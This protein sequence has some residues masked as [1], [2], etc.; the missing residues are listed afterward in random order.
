[1]KKINLILFGIGN[2]GATLL[3][4]L[5]EAREA[6]KAEGI[7]LSIPVIAGSE[8]VL[9]TKEDLPADW[10]E[11]FREKAQDYN[12]GS[13]LKFVSEKGFQN[14]IAIDATAS[15][16]FVENYIE[17]VRSGFHL[18]A[19]NKIA[20]SLSAEFYAELRKE[21]KSNNK[22]FLYETNVGAGL[23]VLE[24]LRNL[25]LSG[26]KVNRVRGVFSGSLSFIFNRFSESDKSFSEVL[27][28]AGEFGFTEPDAREDLSGKDVGRK[29]LIL[30]RELRLQKEFSEVD[31]QSLIPENLG[32]NTSEEE[33]R[34]RIPEL[35]EIFQNHKKTQ[36]KNSVLR[37]IGELSVEDAHL[38][39]RLVSTPEDS[40]LGQLRGAD[41]VI[42]IYTDSY[43]EYPLV[44][45]GA[46]A[47]A[48]VTAR[49]LVTDVLKLSERLN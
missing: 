38:E 44:I 47:G 45:R 9:F 1:M 21:L 37:Y 18:V 12:I 26:E 41:N 5:L 6:W 30:A 25:H 48:A 24:T 15:S 32:E 36:N 46:G 3:D 34:R 2:V 8:K 13:I 23:P 27:K 33:F 17:L 20:N 43:N 19:A 40:P 29:L 39:T 4:Q 49:G 10:R 42:E 28:E 35:D 22:H 14:L 7:L 16:E 11:E 31:I